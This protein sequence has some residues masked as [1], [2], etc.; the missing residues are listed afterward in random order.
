MTRSQRRSST[1]TPS[2]PTAST[3]ANGQL[4][5]EGS[6]VYIVYKN[7]KTAFSSASAFLGLGF[8]FNNVLA[9]GNSGLAESGY[10]VTK[11]NASHP[12]GTWIKNSGNTVYFVGDL[13]LIPVPNWNTFLN[14]GGQAGFIVPANSYDFSLPILSPMTLNDPRLQ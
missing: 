3:Y 7:T 9:V 5:S 10:T 8:S 4:I 1:R 11:A 6:T 14:N 13:G 2:L 12:W